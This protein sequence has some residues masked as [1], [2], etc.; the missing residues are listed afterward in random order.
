MSRTGPAASSRS[1]RPRSGSRRAAAGAFRAALERGTGLR[2]G[3]RAC[4]AAEL[5]GTSRARPEQLLGGRDERGEV[6][7][8]AGLE[9]RL[10]RAP[11]AVGVRVEEVDAAEAVDLEVEEAGHR[12]AAS[13]RRGEAVAG[14]PAVDDLDVARH[15]PAVDDAPLDAEPHRPTAIRMLCRPRRA[16]RGPRASTSARSE[17]IATFAC[18]PLPRARRRPPRGGAGRAPDDAAHAGAE[19]VVRGDDVD[20][21][22]P[23]RLAEPDHRD[24]RDHVEDELLRG[25]GL[26]PRRS[27]EDLRPD[28]DRDLV[29]DERRELRVCDGD[30]AAVSAPAAA[31]ASIAPSTTAFAA[32]ADADHRVAA[33]GRAP[34]PRLR[35]PRRRLPPPPARTAARRAAREQRDDLAGRARRSTRTR[36][37]RAPRAGPTCRADVDQAPAALEALGDRIDDGGDLRRR[38]PGAGNGRVRVVH[39]LDELERRPQIEVGSAALPASVSAVQTR[40]SVGDGSLTRLD[41]TIAASVRSCGPVVNTICGDESGIR[42]SLSEPMIPPK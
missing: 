22:V 12:D 34:R 27:R 16:A 29:L 33:R 23:E 8:D 26:E 4:G 10:A 24:R 31:A 9:Q 28:D 15:Q 30:D 3:R 25:A 2:D 14:D 38:A 18:R 13:V 32:R 41:A 37:R 42:Y 35:P 36:R 19:L 39:Q 21:Q 40:V 1:S 6:G 11:V 20:H 7:G 5:A 17:T